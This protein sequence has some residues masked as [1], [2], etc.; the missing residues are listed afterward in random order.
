MKAKILIILSLCVWMAGCKDDRVASVVPHQVGGFILG[1]NIS[2][3]R[4]QLLMETDLPIRHMEF[5][6]EVEIRDSAGF[7]SGLISYGSCADPG[8]ILRIKLKY[9]DASKE[10]YDELLKAFKERFGEPH[11][12]RGDSFQ[13]VIA[14]KWSFLDADKN[15]ISLIL[16]HNIQDIEQKMGNSVKMTMTSGI[17]KEK[18]CNEVRYAE[19]NI[20]EA[21][22]SEAIKRLR[23][24]DRDWL[25]PR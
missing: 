1:D 10:F 22:P 14:W 3:Y 2:N 15:R 20:E 23:T 17:E 19:K 12:W 16:Q 6:R 8:N 11:E 24:V 25:I 21:K 13:V 5:I 7:K 4:K 18:L 9:N